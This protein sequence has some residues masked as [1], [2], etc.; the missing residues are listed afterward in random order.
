MGVQRRSRSSGRAGGIVAALILC[1]CACI[2]AGAREDEGYAKY[3]DPRQ[4]LNTRMTC[5]D[6]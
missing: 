6:G 4:P 2:A 3:R 5:C 1:Y